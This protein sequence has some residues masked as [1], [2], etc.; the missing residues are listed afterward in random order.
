MPAD[1]FE[2]KTTWRSVCEA[3]QFYLKMAAKETELTSVSVTKT[4]SDYAN[5]NDL[6]SLVARGIAE[7]S[8][9]P[10]K[11][12]LG[13]GGPAGFAASLAVVLAEGMPVE[14]ASTAAM[15]EERRRKYGMNELPKK[16]LTG[17]I[18]FAWEA[19]Q[20]PTLLVLVVCGIISLI[21]G[22]GVEKDW[23]MGWVEGVA[24]GLESNQKNKNDG[25]NCFPNCFPQCLNA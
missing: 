18:V 19:F 5:K 3:T 9:M 1:T 22:L 20:D 10:L 17:F 4:I 11:E 13:V 14:D 16:P 7:E 2:E 15:Y 21:L 12:L 6:A 25:K 24:I 23:A 8:E